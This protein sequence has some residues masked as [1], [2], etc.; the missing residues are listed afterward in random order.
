MSDSQKRK[1]GDTVNRMRE[2]IRTDNFIKK[3]SNENIFSKDWDRGHRR[4]FLCL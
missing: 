4:I 1:V 3:D 2:K